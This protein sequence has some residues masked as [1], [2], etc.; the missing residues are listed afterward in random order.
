MDILGI[1]GQMHS[2]LKGE[3]N[4]YDGFEWNESQYNTWYYK[5]VFD[6]F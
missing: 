5:V 3:T 1:Y 2:V 4:D 6:S